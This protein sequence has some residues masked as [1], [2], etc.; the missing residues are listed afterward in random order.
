M[1]K[2]FL[3][4]GLITTKFAGNRF[5]VHFNC[6]ACRNKSN[7]LTPSLSPLGRGEGDETR[8]F[9][10]FFNSLPAS[11]INGLIVAESNVKLHPAA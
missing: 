9:Y 6:V 2:F 10:N 8:R 3:F 7:P 1:P 11:R 4:V 5:E